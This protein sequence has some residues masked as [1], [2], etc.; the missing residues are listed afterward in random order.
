MAMFESNYNW[1]QKNKGCQSLDKYSTPKR[2][3]YHTK[4]FSPNNKRGF[5]TS[6]KEASF[7][8]W[9]FRTYQHGKITF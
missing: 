8:L 3:M 6:S 5:L 7:V 4:S 1:N 2:S 9:K